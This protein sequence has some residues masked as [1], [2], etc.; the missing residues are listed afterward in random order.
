ME[1][2][3][4][5]EFI[6]DIIEDEAW[7]KFLN[8]DIENRFVD[9]IFTMD[10]Q[11]QQVFSCHMDTFKGRLDYLIDCVCTHNRQNFRKIEIVRIR[12]NRKAWGEI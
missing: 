3:K 4:E 5:T 11:S 8:E 12:K 1:D 6:H 2:E 9:V 10:D 7:N